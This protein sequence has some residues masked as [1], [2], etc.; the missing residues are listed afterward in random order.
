[1]LKKKL[2]MECVL[3]CTDLNYLGVLLA[4][5]LVKCNQLITKIYVVIT[6]E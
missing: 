3:Q 1:M 6:L 5:L 2:L 4:K